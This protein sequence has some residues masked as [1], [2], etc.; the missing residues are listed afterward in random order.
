MCDGESLRASD[1]P[2]FA[3][4]YAGGHV[5]VDADND[6]FAAGVIGRLLAREDGRA[7]VLR[8]MSAWR[9]AGTAE[10]HRAA[11]T[12]LATLAH[13]GDAVPGLVG[14]IVLVCSAIVYARFMSLACARRAVS[15]LP[16][17][18]RKVLLAHHRRSTSLLP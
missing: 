18:Q 10:Q 6:A 4:L 17:D 1:L 8:A 16:A 14:A 9:E 15:R 3:R 11:C 13:R 2:S 7:D 5:A 12:P